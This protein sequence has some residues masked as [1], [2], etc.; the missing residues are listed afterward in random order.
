MD[1]YNYSNEVF[2]DMKVAGLITWHWLNTVAVNRY[3]KITN[4]I[5]RIILVKMRLSKFLKT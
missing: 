4:S 2:Y 5:Y 1:L 3:N